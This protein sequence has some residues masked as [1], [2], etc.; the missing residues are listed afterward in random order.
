MVYLVSK[1]DLSCQIFKT[2]FLSFITLAISDSAKFLDVKKFI[3]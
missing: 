3:Q 1:K 2:P